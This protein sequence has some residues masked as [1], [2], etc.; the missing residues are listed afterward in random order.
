[1]AFKGSLNNL[2]SSA[3]KILGD[4]PIQITY[5]SKGINGSYDPATD[6]Y[7]SVDTQVILKAVKARFSAEEINDSI[8]VNTD[9]K[10]IIA[11]KDL[12]SV[13]PKED[14]YF[15]DEKNLR[16][17]VRVVKSVPGESV[18]ILQCRKA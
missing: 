14:D 4:I 13:I 7:S 6:T 9:A 2:V 10:F 12:N 18:W 11:N 15:L 3:I 16:W 8:I 17:T 5:V 1:M